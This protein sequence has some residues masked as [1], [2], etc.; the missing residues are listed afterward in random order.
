MKKLLLAFAA[1]ALLAEPVAALPIRALQETNVGAPLIEK[2]VYVGTRGS[3]RR[4]VRRR[5][6]RY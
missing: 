4:T 2:A 3:A 5:V 6:R 1:I